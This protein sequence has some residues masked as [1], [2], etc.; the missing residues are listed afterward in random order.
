MQ[1]RSSFRFLRIAC[2][3]WSSEVLLKRLLLLDFDI[4]GVVPIPSPRSVD[5]IS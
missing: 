3:L 1:L 2:K 5:E 4:L